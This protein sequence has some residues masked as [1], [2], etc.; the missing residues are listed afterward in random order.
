MENTN[1]TALSLWGIS[2]ELKALDDL[3][4]LDQGEIS[5]E[6]EQLQ[7]EAQLL[8]EQKVD[9]CVGFFDY[10]KNNIAVAKEKI[11]EL[12][13]FIKHKE[14]KIKNFEIFVKACMDKTG[15]AIFQGEFKQIKLRKPSDIVVIENED[16]VPMEFQVVETTVKIK[17]AE[18]KKALKNGDDIPGATLQKGNASLLMGLKK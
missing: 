5:D 4:M 6:L 18:I 8:L 15:K 11:A 17:K 9:G 13:D 16:E 7:N 2:E 14:N 12:R 10:E 3:L 1:K